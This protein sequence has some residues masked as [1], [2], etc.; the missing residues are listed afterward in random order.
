MI[1]SRKFPATRMRRMRQKK[2]TRELMAETHLTRSDLIYPMFITEGSKK[3]DKIESMPGIERISIDE[4]LKEA[5]EISTIGLPAIALFPSLPDAPKDND[6]TLA[7]DENGLIQTAVRELKKRFPELGVITD[8]ALDTYTDHGQDGLID[9]SSQEILNDKTIDALI[10]QALSH[11]DA[12]VD[13]VAPSDMMDGRIGA[14]RQ[15]LDENNFLNTSILAYSAKYASNFYSPFRQAVA[16]AKGKVEA[17]K[18]TYQMDYANSDE[19]LHEIALDIQEGADMIMV[20][21]GLPYLDVIYRVKQEF[22]MP[23]FA[24]QVTGEYAM[25][26]AAIQNGWLNDTCILESLIGLKRAGSD[27]IL[28]YFAKQIGPQLPTTCN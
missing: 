27:A 5:E 2:F 26:Q 24:Y 7:F 18:R 23:T 12:G 1:T 20:K 3:R 13:I 10:K 4:L 6:A 11:A 25:L 14:I 19:A 21:P 8:I 9:L 22:Q 16:S 28:S 15:A 17:D